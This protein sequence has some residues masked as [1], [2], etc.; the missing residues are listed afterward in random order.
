VVDT[1]DALLVYD[2]QAGRGLQSGIGN[3]PWVRFMCRESRVHFHGVDT[4]ADLRWKIVVDTCLALGSVSSQDELQAF[5]LLKQSLH[6]HVQLV[7]VFLKLIGLPLQAV[8]EFTP[9]VAT[10]GGRK[11]VSF[12][13]YVSFVGLGWC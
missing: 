12:P 13:S 7:K 6:F 11:L 1:H 2:V 5:F 9:S 8:G 10:F 3:S 4:I